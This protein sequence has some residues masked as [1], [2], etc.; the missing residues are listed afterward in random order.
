M[1][2][3]FCNKFFVKREMDGEVIVIRMPTHLLGK[4]DFRSMGD[5]IR[6]DPETTYLTRPFLTSESVPN[7]YP[8]N[9]RR[10]EL[11]SELTPGRTSP[12]ST[13]ETSGGPSLGRPGRPNYVGVRTASREP[14]DLEV[15]STVHRVVTLWTCAGTFRTSD[16]TVH[17]PTGE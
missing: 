12:R 10:P 7:L 5:S 16:P 14:T 6:Q 3:P 17:Q 1:V 15:E 4:R 13:G 2:Y 9:R 11:D 8:L